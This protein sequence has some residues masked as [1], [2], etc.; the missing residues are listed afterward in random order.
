MTND[1]AEKFSD[2]VAFLERCDEKRR[3][4]GTTEF[5]MERGWVSD[6]DFHL[7]KVA[8]QEARDDFFALLKEVVGDFHDDY[9]EVVEK[10]AKSIDKGPNRALL[11][12]KAVVMGR[13]DEMNNL[14]Y[15]YYQFFKLGRERGL[16]PFTGEGEECGHGG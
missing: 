5:A 6:E 8:L 9:S 13:D 11:K 2:L 16:L 10:I 14:D 7:C 4:Y 3:S 12:A 1:F 15:Y